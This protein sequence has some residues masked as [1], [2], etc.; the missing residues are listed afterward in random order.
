M[1]ANATLAS[2]TLASSR[3]IQFE[4]PRRFAELLRSLALCTLIA[5]IVG[6]LLLAGWEVR[7]GGLFK[8]GKGFGYA[9]GLAGG[10][11]MLG[12]LLYPL[13]KRVRFMHEWGTLKFWFWFHM[14]AGILGPVLVLFHSTFR[15]GSFN[16]AVALSC[17]LLVVASGL[18]G[19]FIYR[20]I[21]HGLYG[22]H[23]N[24]KQLEQALAQ[25]CKSLEPILCRMPG[26]K[27]EVERFLELVSRRPASPGART[28]HILSLGAKRMLAERRVQR[29]LAAYAT[30]GADKLVASTANLRK[31]LRTIRST[32][33]A[34]QRHAQF[35]TYERLFSLWHV[36]HIPFLCMLVITALVHVVAVHIY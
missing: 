10:L 33:K 18:V 14:A 21:H 19:R 3:P 22:S 7:H 16:A 20:K 31:L 12:L 2:R 24:L 15:V 1:N 6:A 26:V 8:A 13:R 23:A 34:V 30:A 9:L 25:E 17:M 35:T 29:K 4:L 27:E 32:L 5:V 36:I 11:L 28:L